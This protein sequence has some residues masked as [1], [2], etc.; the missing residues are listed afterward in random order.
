MSPSFTDTLKLV[1]KLVE[2]ILSY[3]EFVVNLVNSN[4]FVR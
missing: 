1:G 4:V 3:L 2:H